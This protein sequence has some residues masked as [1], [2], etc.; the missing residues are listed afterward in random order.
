M[1]Y[2]ISAI[3]I[4]LLLAALPVLAQHSGG[5]AAVNPDTLKWVDP[6]SVHAGSARTS[7][8]CLSLTPPST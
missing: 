1:G 6:P 3:L 2:R 5:H 7:C 8:S 4:V